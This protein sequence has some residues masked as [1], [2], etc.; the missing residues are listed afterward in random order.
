MAGFGQTVMSPTFLCIYIFLIVHVASHAYLTNP[1]GRLA[2]LYGA[3]QPVNK[4]VHAVYGTNGV[5]PL[6]ST[7]MNTCGFFDPG[8]TTATTIIGGSRITVSWKMVLPH[9]GTPE[10]IRVAFSKSQSNPDFTDILY[11]DSVTPDVS[12]SGQGV[13]ATV[14]VQVTLPAVVDSATILQWIWDSSVDGG[15]YIDCTDLNLIDACATTTCVA[16]D[17]C[18][19][20]GQCQT[21]WGNCTNPKK[22]DGTAC[23]LGQCISGVCTAPVSAP[24]LRYALEELVGY[25]NIKDMDPWCKHN[26]GCTLAGDDFP[27]SLE[28]AAFVLANAARAD[29]GGF[30]RRYS[31][32]ASCTSKDKSMPPYWWDTGL[33]QAARV[34]VL[35][36]ALSSST[37]YTMDTCPTSCQ[38]YPKTDPTAADCRWQDR[39]SWFLNAS[40]LFDGIDQGL[41]DGRVIDTEGDPLAAIARLVHGGPPSRSRNLDVWACNMLLG[42]WDMGMAYYHQEG[43][44]YAD[45][46]TIH[47][48]WHWFYRRW[49]TPLRGG[50]GHFL[51]KGKVRYVVNY[52]SQWLPESVKLVY[53]NSKFDMQRHTGEPV[54]GHLFGLSTKLGSYFVDLP[55]PAEIQVGEGANG[56]VN[57]PSY[58][59]VVR[60]NDGL[61]RFPE[62]GYLHT[63]NIS[64]C[65]YDYSPGV[66]TTTEWQPLPGEPFYFNYTVYGWDPDTGI[67]LGGLRWALARYYQNTHKRSIGL[68]PIEEYHH[69]DNTSAWQIVFA[70][71]DDPERNYWPIPAHELVDLLMADPL[72]ARGQIGVNWGGLQSNF[73]IV[74]T[75]NT[76]GQS[77]SASTNSNLIAAGV[78]L[79]IISLAVPA[80]LIWKRSFIITTMEMKWMSY[81]LDSHVY[82]IV[83]LG[84]LIWLAT[85]ISQ[86]QNTWAFS[87]DDVHGLWKVCIAGTCYDSVK[88]DAD[89]EAAIGAVRAFMILAQFCSFAGWVAPISLITGFTVPTHVVTL[90]TFFGLALSIYFLFLSVCIYAAYYTDVLHPQPFTNFYPGWCWVLATVAFL[91]NIVAALIA[92]P[93]ISQVEKKQAEAAVAAKN[94]S[95]GPKSVGDWEKFFDD[96]YQTYYYYNHRTHETTWAKQPGFN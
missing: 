45:T 33:Q 89:H 46:W 96:K 73:T 2:S 88:T 66:P 47:T 54:E 63:Y 40:E 64:N 9:V 27:T 14:S 91:A 69:P 67:D 37:C 86:A 41:G 92:L 44:Q 82:S 77:S 80:V 23:S 36:M 13:G 51:H 93:L 55:I 65:A 79:A 4:Y 5:Y 28:R 90:T 68:W 25:Y 26:S 84:L 19:N 29:I 1:P 53:E 70:Y 59:F 32:D 72:T 42:G 87:G 38:L 62:S 39:V 61:F 95:R 85:V 30:A 6:N 48:T 78:L 49:L 58:Y 8:P 12:G 21:P 15:G 74:G 60:N 81:P 16:L 31:I 17:E 20:V 11:D 94:P 56:E 52:F 7:F 24:A 43:N 71:T 75:P 10:R 57:C 22:Q 34:H 18:H 83:G 3:G 35:D 50:G 76:G